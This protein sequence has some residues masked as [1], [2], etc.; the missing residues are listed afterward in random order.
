[1]ARRL[2]RGLLEIQRADAEQLPFPDGM[3]TCAAMTGVL[4]FLPDP[5]AALR[6]IRRVLAS[7]GRLVVLGADPA[8][9]GTPAAPEPMASRLHF[10]ED[11]EHRQL[12]LAAGFDRATVVRRDLEP[13][14]RQVGVPEEHLAL[15]A[16]QGT[17]FLLAFKD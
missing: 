3:F 12:A 15:F 9:R 11:D 8:L 7:G 10:Y 13:F 1:M 16:G 6:E 17:P 2:R 14:A 4:G 5:V